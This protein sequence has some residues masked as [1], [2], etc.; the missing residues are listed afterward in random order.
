LLEVDDVP[1][2]I[3]V[4]GLDILVLEVECVLPNIDPNDGDICYAAKGISKNARKIERHRMGW[5]MRY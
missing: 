1:D 2:G 5:E 3:Q 4:V